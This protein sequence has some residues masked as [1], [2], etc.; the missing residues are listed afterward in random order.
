MK[1]QIW[2]FPL[3]PGAT[4]V[5]MPYKAEVLTVQTQGETVCLWALVNPVNDTENRQFE[6]YGTGHNI[7]YDMGTERKYIGTIQMQEG[8]LIFHVFER[9]N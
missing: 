6:V 2:K 3:N 9:I 7:H 1:K 4:I 5:K 8:A